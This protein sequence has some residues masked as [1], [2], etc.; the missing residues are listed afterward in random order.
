MT[1]T[2]DL[3][4]LTLTRLRH[5]ERIGEMWARR[6]RRPLG[7]DVERLLF[8]AADHPARGALAVRGESMAMESRGDLL[9]RLAEALR[10]PGVDG[11]LGTP[12]ILEDLLLLGLLEDK[13]VIGSM[14]RG[15]IAGAS[16]E[17]DDRFTAYDAPH[18][19]AAGIDGG[20]MLLRIALDDADTA[21][22][23]QACADAVTDLARHRLMA[24]VEPFWSRRDHRGRVGNLLDPDSV[25]TSIH[26]AAGIGATSA[27]TWLKLPVVE[28]MPRVLDATTLPA[29]LLGG[30]PRENPDVTFGRWQ[31]AL[32]HPVARGLVAGRTLL[33]PP[34][35]RVAEA[36][37]VASGI[38][39]TTT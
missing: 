18:L 37:D 35:G 19:A 26:V 14:N 24:M 33:Y 29:L 15:G 25:I 13:I 34:D 4:Q 3:E 9:R 30:D 28:D 32:A 11:V 21:P 31:E 12:D 17:F 22:T 5:P 27:Y 16:F 1:D 38:V 10:R 2:L 23:L 39:H 7:S 36:V 6:R 20:K 8:V